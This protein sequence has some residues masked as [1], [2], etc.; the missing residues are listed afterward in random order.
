[1]SED[2]AEVNNTCHLDINTNTK[3]VL[4]MTPAGDPKQGLLPNPAC[5]TMAVE[6]RMWNPGHG[7]VAVKS[8]RAIWEGVEIY[9]M[10]NDM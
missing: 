1:M 9:K 3:R 6:P 10:Q 7:R 4:K 2:F 5:G 8:G